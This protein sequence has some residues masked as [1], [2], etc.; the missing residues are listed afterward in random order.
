M[1]KADA[2]L[3]GY[4][5][6]PCQQG[7]TFRKEHLDRWTPETPD[8]RFPRMSYGLSNTLNTKISSFWMGDASYCRLKNLQLSYTLPDA[9]VRKAKLGKVCFFANA[10]N[11]FT[12]T[13]YYQGYDPEN[14]YSGGSDGV[15]TGAFASNYPLVRTYTFGVE[16]KF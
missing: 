12:I 7:G 9:A 3:S 1:G 4:Y 11:L 2:Y 16:L 10:T 5:T 6:Q 15:T 14:Q 8:G 13:R